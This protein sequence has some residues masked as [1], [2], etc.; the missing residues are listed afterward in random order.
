M[1]AETN[2][3]QK[4]RKARLSKAQKRT[5]NNGKGSS[6]TPEPRLAN[7]DASNPAQPKL[8]PAGSGAPKPVG[9]GFPEWYPTH[10][11]DAMS[12]LS[13]RQGAPTHSHRYF[14]EDG[15]SAT[16]ASSISAEDYSAGLAISY[17]MDHSS[18]SSCYAEARYSLCASS[19]AASM[20]ELTQPTSRFS[21]RICFQGGHQI[22]DTNQPYQ[23]QHITTLP[24]S[25][26]SMVSHYQSQSSRPAFLQGSAQLLQPPN[27]DAVGLPSLLPHFPALLT[28]PEPSQL[29]PH[30][31]T[32]YAPLYNLSCQT[33]SPSEQ[34][35]DSK[36]LYA[37]RQLKNSESLPVSTAPIN[38]KQDKSD[39]PSHP[40]RSSLPSHIRPKI[41]AAVCQ[42]TSSSE[43]II[44]S[45]SL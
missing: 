5:R 20:S 14:M 44:N 18:I 13:C 37:K 4:H 34:K 17:T 16:S 2:G 26:F 28:P 10:E 33:G 42:L 40:S 3:S 11:H 43:Q 8:E 22:N 31:D 27:R 12:P 25:N 6:C 9:S 24:S 36:D 7:C 19:N 30:P 39:K 38:K 41:W 29:L 1:T 45:Y 23:T 32:P 15:T 35:Q 21:G